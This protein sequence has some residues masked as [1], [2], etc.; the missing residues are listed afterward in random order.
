MTAF[1][2]STTSKK[3]TII[4]W[5]LERLG[6]ARLNLNLE[7]CCFAKSSIRFLGYK[8]SEAGIEV[9]RDRRERLLQELIP[10]TGKKLKGVLATVPFLRRHLPYFGEVA[11]PLYSFQNTKGLLADAEGWAETGLP[12]VAAC[13]KLQRSPAILKSP[14]LGVPLHLETNV[15]DMGYVGSLFQLEPL[16]QIKRYIEFVSRSFKGACRDH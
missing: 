10:T 6:K 9:D 12:A 13:M 5:V 3:N 8:V 1:A 16:T 15:F 11:A 14:L 4:G 7:K 2:F